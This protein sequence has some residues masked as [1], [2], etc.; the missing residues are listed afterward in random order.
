[1]IF[2]QKENHAGVEILD[3]PRETCRWKHPA[4]GSPHCAPCCQ[5]RK[6]HKACSQAMPVDSPRTFET[7]NAFITGG[8]GSNTADELVPTM[9]L[10]WQLDNAGFDPRFLLHPCRECFQTAQLKHAFAIGGPAKH[11]QRGVL[12]L[13]C[14]Y[15]FL[16]QISRTQKHQRI[17]TFC[18][19]PLLGHH[20]Q[21]LAH[22]T[23]LIFGINQ[24]GSSGYIEKQ[25]SSPLPLHQEDAQLRSGPPHAGRFQSQLSSPS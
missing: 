22:L 24:N 3:E 4:T 25:K 2:P 13:C 1:M 10:Q 19:S 11:Y 17:Q 7:A 20:E 21:E 5:A 6:E 12:F 9:I 8:S 23:D 14:L 18:P 15:Q 16:T